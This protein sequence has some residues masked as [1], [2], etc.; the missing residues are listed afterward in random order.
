M[1]L[2][3][4]FKKPINSLKIS[5]IVLTFIVP[6]LIWHAYVFF[7]YIE[8]P[9]GVLHLL[10]FERSSSLLSSIVAFLG[11]LILGYG[12]FILL[13]KLK[14]KGAAFWA[15]FIWMCYLIL[16]YLGNI[17][18]FFIIGVSSV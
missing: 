13:K 11:L 5:L 9:L 18:A 2:K 3:E 14:I 6:F 15:Y 17:I 8:L 1:D 16:F 7:M 10:T 12:S 4:F